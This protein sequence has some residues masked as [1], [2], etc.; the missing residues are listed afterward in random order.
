MFFHFLKL[1]LNSGFYDGSKKVYETPPSLAYTEKLNKILDQRKL[2]ITERAKHVHCAFTEI[3]FPYISS[4]Q[5]YVGN[6][7]PYMFG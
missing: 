3:D 7:N 5:Q 2:L 4:N 1:V 6:D